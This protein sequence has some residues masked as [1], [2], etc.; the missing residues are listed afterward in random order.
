MRLTLLGTGDAR[1]VS[2]YGCDCA[3]CG[4]ARNDANLRRRPCRRS[5]RP[6]AITMT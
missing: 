4:L 6:R 3:A 2:V 5:H 1:Q